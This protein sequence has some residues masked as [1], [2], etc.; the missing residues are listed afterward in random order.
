MATPRRTSAEATSEIAA[1]QA[2]AAQAR[3][4]LEQARISMNGS[5]NFS[6]GSD[7]SRYHDAFN[8]VSR[9]SGVASNADWKVKELQEEAKRLQYEE[10]IRGNND[11]AQ[12]QVSG[13]LGEL[14]DDPVDQMLMQQL[15]GRTQGDVPYSDT[16]T[17]AMMTQ[18]GEQAATGQQAAVDRLLRSGMS[19][20]DP[21]FHAALAQLESGRQGSLQ[22]LRTQIDSQANLANY[23]AR[24]QAIGQ[25]GGLNAQRNNAITGQANLNADYINSAPVF[26]FAGGPGSPGGGGGMPSGG[27]QSPA[28][29]PAPGPAP[30]PAPRP[31]PG[32]VRQNGGGM[33]YGGNRTPTPT[34]TASGGAFNVGT[35]SL[36]RTSGS[37]ASGG[38][39]GTPGSS[40]TWTA[41]GSQGRVTGANPGMAV[42]SPGGVGPRVPP[43]AAQRNTRLP[44]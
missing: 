39:Q 44:Y 42:Q 41:T 19:P 28:P 1:Q 29:R 11:R 5:N 32:P 23:D 17:N 8:A 16:V 2:A 15:T 40:P 21:A 4:E 37:V 33:V 13:R 14:R 31:A 12:A 25:L 43:P 20:S 34:T 6:F 26:D 9:F 7:R 22:S 27:G 35:G 36:G 18:R 38:G 3:I 24:G 10:E 30:T